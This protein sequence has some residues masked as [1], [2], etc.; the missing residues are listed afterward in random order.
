MRLIKL[1]S[2]REPQAICSSDSLAAAA[3]FQEADQAA[4]HNAARAY[5]AAL[6]STCVRDE[7]CVMWLANQA[8]LYSLC[9]SW[10]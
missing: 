6:L 8:V 4:S 2:T 5:A 7:A 1:Q 3:V 10:S 9:H